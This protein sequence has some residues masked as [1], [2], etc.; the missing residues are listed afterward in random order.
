[1]VPPCWASPPLALALAL[2]SVLALALGSVLALAL[3]SVLGPLEA[4]VLGAVLGAV[5]SVDV[6]GAVLGAV[7]GAVLGAVDGVLGVGV[8]VVPLQAEITRMAVAP[9]ARER[10]HRPWDFTMWFLL[11]QPWT[12]EAPEPKNAA[13]SYTEVHGPDV[14]SRNVN[15][16]TTSAERSGCGPECQ[17]PARG[18]RASRSA[19]PTRLNDTTMI[20]RIVPGMNR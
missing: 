16:S 20:T 12:R 7:D 18:S 2:G 9:Y 13:R 10:A 14:M 5:D 8:A 11:Q 6:D 17:R 1:M 4:S 3:G 19:S 15:R